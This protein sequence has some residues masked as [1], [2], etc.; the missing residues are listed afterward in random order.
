MFYRNVIKISALL[1]LITILGNISDVSCF[2]DFENLSY[3]R[4][5]LSGVA[6]AYS[7]TPP[8]PVETTTKKS[9]FFSGIKNF[10]S[11]SSTEN[12][13]EIISSTA[14]SVIT[15]K[16]SINTIP[17]Q[18]PLSPKGQN[19]FNPP[20][21]G[22]SLPTGTS[23]S[24]NRDYINPNVGPLS[25]DTSIPVRPPIAGPVLNPSTPVKNAA[26]TSPTSPS[27]RRDYVAPIRPAAPNHGGGTSFPQGSSSTSTSTTILPTQPNSRRDYVNPHLPTPKSPLQPIQPV[28][29]NHPNI[30][31]NQPTSSPAIHPPNTGGRRDYVNPNVGGQ[32][33][34]LN[35][36]DFPALPTPKNP[37]T[38]DD[39]PP[40]PP[41][42][43]HPG[44][45]NPNPAVPTPNSAWSK[46][47]GQPDQNRVSFVPN[48][49][50]PSSTVNTIG[51]SVGGAAKNKLASDE[52]IS[53]L[54]ENLLSKDS[55][56]QNKHITLNLQGKT[57]STER[58]D[59]APN[60]LMEVNEVAFES[61]TIAKMRL[62]FNNYEL[63]T[64]VNEH[65]TPIE[66]KEENDFLDAVMATTVMRQ[67]MSFLQNKGLLTPDP[68][69]HR[70]L[71][72][73]I[74]FTMYSRGQGR[75][76]SSGFEHVFLTEVKNDTVIGLHNWV[77]FYEEEKAGHI[78][79]KGYIKKID[80][81]NR[82]S[83]LKYR[84]DLNN[85][86][87]PVNTLFIGTSPE[88]EMA[89]YT[90]CFQL[91]PDK[92]CPIT[93]NG[94]KINIITHTWRYRGKSLIGSAFPEI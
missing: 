6:P 61:P 54:T 4:D 22:Q 86:Q 94:N 35:A 91:R 1:C 14:P 55:N 5:V 79:Y 25:G 67:A 7:V 56:N 28:L 23:L 30:L 42:R 37:P 50:E 10:F 82:G 49:P 80:L 43:R 19:T 84:F 88:L 11:R 21:G 73:T 33:N 89:L 64:L 63:D 51:D 38:K 58:T 17:V 69:T 77:Y 45:P 59:E 74:W 12:S 71:M 57:R 8:P 32:T 26:S 29:P 13:K 68:K 41:P 40:L 62:L 46:P 27:N 53:I 3:G 65:V 48:Q 70:D 44:Q 78:D 66:R 31:P 72:K 85:L 34:P 36:N 83:I 47:G 39:F 76:G 20:I 90:I 16:P 81:G 93:L 60:K 75:I 52:E 18:S 92:D 24:S 2:S 87:K 9:G 15:P